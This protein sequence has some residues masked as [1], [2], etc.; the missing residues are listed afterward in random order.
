MTITM[1]YASALPDPK[2]ITHSTIVPVAPSTI[3][4][5]TLHQQFNDLIAAFQIPII[6]PGAQ[7]IVE[8]EV[9]THPAID[10]YPKLYLTS[11]SNIRLKPYGFAEFLVEYQIAV[12]FLLLG[13]WTFLS[14]LYLWYLKNNT[15]N[16]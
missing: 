8:L 7:Y 12:N 3:L 15:P 2:K 10:E 14:L 1:A 9:E 16:A 4:P 6:H 11:S 13:V 5:D